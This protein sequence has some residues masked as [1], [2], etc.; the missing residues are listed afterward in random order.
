VDEGEREIVYRLVKIAC[1]C[2]SFFCSSPSFLPSLLT[3]SCEMSEFG[4]RVNRFIETV[5]CGE[6][7]DVTGDRKVLFG[8]GNWGNKLV[9]I[10]FVLVY[11][12]RKE[13]KKRD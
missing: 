2:V 3:S 1:E 4:R 11:K 7:G 12:M 8:G 10:N 5:E 9:D 6:F 13:W